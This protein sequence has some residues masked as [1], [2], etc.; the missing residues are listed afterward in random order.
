MVGLFQF[1]KGVLSN[2]EQRNIKG[3]RLRYITG[4]KSEYNVKKAQLRSQKLSFSDE[5]HVDA[6][7]GENVYCIEW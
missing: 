7:S 5:S 6:I 3:G 2:S 1:T 4:T